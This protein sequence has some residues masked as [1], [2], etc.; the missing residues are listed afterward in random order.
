MAQSSSIYKASVSLSNLNTHYYEDL[1][2]VMAKH[3]SEPESRM[4]F[5]LLAFLFCAHEQLEFSKGLDDVDQPAIWQKDH[6]GAIQHW[7]ELGQPDEKRIRQACGR[8]NQVSIFTYQENR[9]IEWFNKTG[10][11]LIDNSKVKIYHLVV[12]EN[13]PI[14]KLVDKS[15]NLTCVIEDELM[16]LGNDDERVAIS[17]VRAVT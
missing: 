6:T 4:M 9:G 5:R 2:L 10:K 12:Q 1:N 14:E 13:G 15:M 7:V 11:K 8:S 17:I 16:H 3:P